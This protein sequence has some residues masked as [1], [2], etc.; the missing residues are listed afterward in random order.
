MSDL[1]KGGLAKGYEWVGVCETRAYVR[2]CLHFACVRALQACLCA[3][4]FDFVFVSVI[5]ASL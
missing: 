1:L 3:S 2:K 4:P 5:D